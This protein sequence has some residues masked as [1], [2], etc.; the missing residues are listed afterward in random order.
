MDIVILKISWRMGGHSELLLLLL[1]CTTLSYFLLLGTACPHAGVIQISTRNDI[2]ECN[3]LLPWLG[4]LPGDIKGNSAENI[5]SAFFVALYMSSLK[6]SLESIKTPRYLTS[7][8]Q[9]TWLPSILTWLH[10][11]A[12]HLEKSIAMLFSAIMRIRRLE[13]QTSNAYGAT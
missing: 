1:F 6:V 2:T 8:A 9:R 5:P 10:G 4:E 13:N 12:R 7:H 3:S 11:A